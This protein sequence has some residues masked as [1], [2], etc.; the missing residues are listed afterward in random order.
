MPVLIFQGT[1]TLLMIPIP[2]PAVF[3]THAGLSDS[4]NATGGLLEFLR[5]AADFRKSAK[6]QMTD[7]LPSLLFAPLFTW[8][9]R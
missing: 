7:Y 6:C 3:C 2:L 5:A 4:V 1:I 9:F 8:L